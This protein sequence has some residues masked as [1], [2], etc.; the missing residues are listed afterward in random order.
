MCRT[1]FCWAL[2]SSH[3]VIVR[4]LADVAD[5]ENHGF[6]AKLLPPVRRAEYFCSDVA[7]FMSDRHFAIAGIFE[8]LT[9]LNEDQGR[10][11][12]MAGP[13]DNASGRNGKPAEAQ[14]AALDM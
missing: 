6:F 3:I 1:L 8:N 14:F 13:W 11:I 5:I 12:V 7:S 9:L 4:V 10:P 2:R